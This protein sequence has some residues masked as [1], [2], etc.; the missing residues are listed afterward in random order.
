MKLLDEYIGAG[1]L[2]SPTSGMPLI[3]KLNIRDARNAKTLQKGAIYPKRKHDFISNHFTSSAVLQKKVD[4]IDAYYDCDSI[5]AILVFPANEIAQLYINDCIHTIK[6]KTNLSSIPLVKQKLALIQYDMDK[7][8]RAFARRCKKAKA[9]DT[10]TYVYDYLGVFQD[11]CH[12]VLELLKVSAR[13]MVEKLG[14]DPEVAVPLVMASSTL[15][16]ACDVWKNFWEEMKVKY[17]YDFKSSYKA[18]DLHY[19]EQQ[20]S[21]I[22]SAVS[23]KNDIKLMENKTFVGWF[24][25]YAD[26]LYSPE[27]VNKIGVKAFSYSP[28]LKGKIDNM[29]INDACKKKRINKLIKELKSK[30]R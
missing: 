23:P 6:T 20:W 28:G 19:I 4:K 25:K 1:I 30:E 8:D 12:D 5:F 21:Y 3:D 15:H 9:G 22:E 14:Y 27:M 18:W 10:T 29:S 26:I 7:Y 11:E 2:P 16:F 17:R 24:N 13:D